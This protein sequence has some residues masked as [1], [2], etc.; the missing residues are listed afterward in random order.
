[1][2]FS[3]IAYGILHKPFYL[4]TPEEFHI[5]TEKQ[6]SGKSSGITSEKISYASEKNSVSLNFLQP[7]SLYK[8]KDGYSLF[9]V[10]ILR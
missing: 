10:G 7:L 4:K 9:P 6:V 8:I 2:K 5:G 1:M 3:K